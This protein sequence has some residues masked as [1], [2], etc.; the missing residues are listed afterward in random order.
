MPRKLG[1]TRRTD[2]RQRK[3][4]FQVPR[5]EDATYV[6]APTPLAGAESPTASS[7][8]QQDAA[9]AVAAPVRAAAAV[10]RSPSRSIPRPAGASRPMFPTAAFAQAMHKSSGKR[11]RGSSALPECD[12]FAEND[13]DDDTSSSTSDATSHS[14]R[15]DSY[16]GD[17]EEEAFALFADADDI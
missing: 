8:A 13:S 14:S 10:L 2:K 1:L 9:L 3:A 12:S 15:C 6:G 4:G 16:R 17:A 5:A 11:K 7:V